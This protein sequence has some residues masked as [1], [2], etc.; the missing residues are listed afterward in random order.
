MSSPAPTRARPPS[1]ERVLAPVRERFADADPAALAAVVRAVVAAERD[2]LTDG[3]E[4]LAAD[5]LAD[6]AVARILAFTDS[7]AEGG[8]VPPG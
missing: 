7:A 6:K 3:A 1:V 2:R 5:A 4:P 8:P